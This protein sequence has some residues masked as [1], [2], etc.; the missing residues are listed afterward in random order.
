LTTVERGCLRN[1]VE[2]V[3]GEGGSGDGERGREARTFRREAVKD[4][5]VLF[6]NSS[7]IDPM[8]R[9]H[10]R[11]VRVPVEFRTRRK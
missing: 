2:G 5:P 8:T 4:F 3:S 7:M 9:E 10:D 6:R 1:K 11:I